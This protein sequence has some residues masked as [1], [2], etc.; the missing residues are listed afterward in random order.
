[1]NGNNESEVPSEE[2]HELPFGL[3]HFIIS[4]ALSLEL[5]Q[6][7]V[8][9]LNIVYENEMIINFII[10]RSDEEASREYYCN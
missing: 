4:G 8:V 10:L 6:S 5:R 7:G 3:Y 1:V 2:V 9:S